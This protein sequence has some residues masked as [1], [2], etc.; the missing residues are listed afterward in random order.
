MNKSVTPG[1]P[2]AKVLAN[3]HMK[4]VSKS[5]TGYS[6]CCPAHDD[7]NPSLSISEGSDERVLLHCHAGC[8]LKEILAAMGLEEVDLFQTPDKRTSR[9]NGAHHAGSARKVAA[10]TA[11]PYK[12]ATG[13]L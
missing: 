10:I 9:T 8:T 6:A 7:H 3:A 5:G 1:T 2:L 12:N 11:Y 13:E 4:R